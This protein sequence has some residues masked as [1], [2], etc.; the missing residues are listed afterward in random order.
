MGLYFLNSITHK[1]KG[2]LHRESVGLYRDDGLAVI[3]G[4]AAESV[5]IVKKLHKEFSK[6]DLKIKTEYGESA[7]DFLNLYMDLKNDCYRQ[8][9]KPNNE[10][11]YH[12]D[13]KPKISFGN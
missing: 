7:T 12:T 3:C 11:I 4:G 10:P 1:S 2:I 6:P 9:K 5:R 8:W 13:L